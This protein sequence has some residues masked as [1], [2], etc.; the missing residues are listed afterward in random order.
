MNELLI[1]IAVFTLPVGLASYTAWTHPGWKG[2]LVAVLTLWLL[3]FLGLVFLAGRFGSDGPGG[4]LAVLWALSG[5]LWSAAYCSLL[6]WIR[7]R[8][9]SK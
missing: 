9:A 6:G 8:R 4:L 1:T 5:W 7:G 3:L 2:T